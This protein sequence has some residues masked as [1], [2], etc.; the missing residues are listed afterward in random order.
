MIYLKFEK[1]LFDWYVIWIKI[2]KE[3]F[4]RWR[5]P[6]M[7]H[8]SETTWM[9]HLKF[10]INRFIWYVITIKIIEKYVCRWCMSFW[11]GMDLEVHKCCSVT[12]NKLTIKIWEK[13]VRSMSD[14]N[15]YH[16]RMFLSLVTG[17]DKVWRW[18]YIKVAV[19]STINLRAKCEKNWFI[20]CIV[21]VKLVKEH[22]FFCLS[23]SLMR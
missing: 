6:L 4:F 2:A 9:L 7:R 14:F 3:Y 15:Q 20:G 19:S 12:D 23:L 13:L 18:K 22:F 8:G 1:N 5:M 17:P 11:W 16:K 10:E 21:S